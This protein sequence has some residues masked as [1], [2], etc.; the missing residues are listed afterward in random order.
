MQNLTKF[1][2]LSII[3]A[4]IAIL[5]ISAI[6][7]TSS[8]KQPSTLGNENYTISQDDRGD[9]IEVKVLKAPESAKVYVNGE[10]IKGDSVILDKKKEYTITATAED[11]KKYTAK[12]IFGELHRT[13]AVN[14]EPANEAGDQYQQNHIEEWSKL[15]DCETGLDVQVLSEKYPITQ[16]IAYN[17]N[18]FN[19]AWDYDNKNQE[20]DNFRLTVEADNSNRQ[21]AIWRIEN[22]ADYHAKDYKIEFKNF[23]NPF[24]LEREQR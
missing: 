8:T 3:A 22:T 24:T 16:E 1:Q 13:I 23:T 14:M 11:F 2:K 4:T 21:Y 20:I 9:Q 15:E 7:A 5:V 17:M 6:W 10:E 18:G 19:L 12:D